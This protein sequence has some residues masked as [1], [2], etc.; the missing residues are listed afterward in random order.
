M[1][2]LNA[3]RFAPCSEAIRTVINP[4][5]PLDRQTICRNLC[6]EFLIKQ[7]VIRLKGGRQ[8]NLSTKAIRKKEA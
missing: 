5:R 2:G 4:S 7:G 8:I 6:E 3:T 1:L